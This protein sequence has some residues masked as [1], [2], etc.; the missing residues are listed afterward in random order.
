MKTQYYEI[1][2]EKLRV[3]T[4][5]LGAHLIS[6]FV[7]D[8]DGT[9]YDY[10]LGYRDVEDCFDDGGC[11]GAVVG[12]VV[13]RIKDAEF[14]LNGVQY[15]LTK[16]Q[17]ENQIH[18]GI[19]G[20]DCKWFDVKEQKAD[21]I[22]YHYTSADGEEGY[23]GTLDM[24]V[25]FA[26]EADSLSVRF[27]ATTDKDTIFNPTCHIYF[28]LSDDKGVI[29]DHELK[30]DADQIAC[31]DKDGIPTGEMQDVEGSVFDFRKLRAIGKSIHEPVQTLIERKGYDHAFLL[32][33]KKEDEPSVVVLHPQ[34]GRT[35]EIRTDLPVVQVYTGN[36]LGGANGKNGIQYEDFTGVAIETQYITDSIHVEKEP[37]VILRTGDVFKSESIYTFK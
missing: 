34:T 31:V 1:K 36:Y 25:T 7:K 20:F 16:N 9:E 5:N 35:V 24:D 8:E 28:N 26:V 14:T 13:N 12:R 29:F 27:Y 2:S 17:G 4:S 37:K 10:V 19:E 15:Y 6:V 18:G 22:T 11:I 32:N 33:E 30:I 21:S 3:V 23:P